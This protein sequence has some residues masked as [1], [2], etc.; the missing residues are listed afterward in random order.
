[1]QMEAQAVDATLEAGGRSNIDQHLINDVTAASVPM[2]IDAQGEEGHARSRGIKRVAEEE[3][4][5]TESSKK[6][7]IGEHFSC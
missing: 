6:A 2:E 7:K 1:M 5:I 4:T 3:P